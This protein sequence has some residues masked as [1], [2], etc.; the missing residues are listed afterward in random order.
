M[1]CR[2]E[3]IAYLKGEWVTS[4][5]GKMDYKYNFWVIPIRYRPNPKALEQSM[6]RQHEIYKK[7]KLK[8]QRF[9]HDSM[10]RQKYYVMK[11][12]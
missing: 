1:S 8:T 9:Y 12:T 7:L 4:P 5:C 3:F 11:R 10:Y 6:R 2:K